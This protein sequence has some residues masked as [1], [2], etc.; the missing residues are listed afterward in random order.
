MS[1][2]S[3]IVPTV[4]EKTLEAVLASIEKQ[5]FR[6]FEVV[7]VDS[8][9]DRR[10]AE[11]VRRY[12]FKAIQT[13]RD[14]GL[15]KA[16]CLAS[17]QSR[18]RF[19]LL[20][21]ATKMLKPHALFILNELGKKYDMVAIF[22]G[23]SGQGTWTALARLDKEVSTSETNVY[24]H[25]ELADFL[26]PRF[27]KKELLDYSLRK[28]ESKLP[29]AVFSR[30]LWPEDR[31]IFLQARQVSNSVGL[32]SSRLITHIGDDTFCSVVKKYHR[33]GK[34]Y[35]ELRRFNEFSDL[36]K[37]GSRQRLIAECSYAERIGLISLYITRSIS[38]LLGCYVM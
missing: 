32:S 28:L 35:R 5:T 25:G 4:G 21:D 31:L 2:I 16:R 26:I 30:V 3:V 37:L 10:I 29:E 27:Y 20:L 38:F 7:V 11:L 8:S 15:L 6:D 33:Y 17:R 1:S 14:V 12:G 9:G 23:R 19:V 36:I 18:G 34:S 24:R 22:E 13:T